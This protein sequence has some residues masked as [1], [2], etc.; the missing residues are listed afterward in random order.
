VKR[1]ALILLVAACFAAT[2]FAAD[3][4]VRIENAWVRPADP[5]QA[6]VPLFADIVSNA[7]LKLVGAQT[8]VAKVA[9]LMATDNS[10]TGLSTIK[11]AKSFDIAAGAPFRLAPRG[12][13][14][15]LRDVMQRLR[16]GQSVPFTLQ[17]R[18]AD[19]K[20]LRVDAEAAVRGVM[21]RPE[22]YDAIPPSEVAP[23]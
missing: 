17:L 21:P 13:F 23:R 6:G 16:T 3:P 20:A 15:Q 7:P 14:I 5:G 11:S 2:A 1:P 10:A 8:P 22:D 4:E 12:S 19:G 18:T 9:A